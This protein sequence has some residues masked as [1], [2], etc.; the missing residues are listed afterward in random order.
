MTTANSLLSRLPAC[1]TLECI[2]NAAAR[3]AFNLWKPLSGYTSAQVLLLAASIWYNSIPDTVPGLWSQKWPSPQ[4]YFQS[5]IKLCTP[6]PLWSATSGLHAR[7]HCTRKYPFETSLSLLF[8][9][10]DLATYMFDVATLC[11]FN[12]LRPS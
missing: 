12:L 6:N 11:L 9:T 1:N 4:L 5:F 2:Q 8:F 7:L 3:L 10:F